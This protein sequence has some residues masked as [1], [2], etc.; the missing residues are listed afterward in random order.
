MKNI[1]WKDVFVFLGIYGLV[2]FVQITASYFTYSSLIDWYPEL[3]LPSWNPP[4]WVFGPVWTVLYVLIAF[5]FWLIVMSEESESKVACYVL[6][7]LQ[8]IANFMWTI[9]FFGIQNPLLALIDIFAL[10]VLIGLSIYY[11]GKVNKVAA[12]IMVPY[13][14][15]VAYAT[16]LNLGIYVLN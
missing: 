3:T 5:A 16:T 11:Y 13:F 8:L 12:W 1:N 2:M 15:W 4:S 6:F 14:L 7:F 9:F 10:L